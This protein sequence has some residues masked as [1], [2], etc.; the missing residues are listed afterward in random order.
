M[1]SS[2]DGA[3]PWPS[4]AA[5]LVAVASGLVVRGFTCDD[6][7]I[8]Y[9]FAEQAAAGHPLG[10]VTA[11][12]PLVSGFSNPTWTLALA[13]LARLGLPVAGSAKALGIVCF[14]LTAVLATRL[15]GRLTEHRA[16]AWAGCLVG[17]S[18]TLALWSVSGLENSLVAL[19]VVATALL[20]VAEEQDERRG[21]RSLGSSAAVAVLVVSR[22]DAFTYLAAAAFARALVVRRRPDAGWGTAVGD[23]ARWVAAPVVVLAG[24]WA[25]SL[26]RFGYVLANTYYAKVDQTVGDRLVSLTS[27][28]G[29]LAVTRD[30]LLITG[31][32]LIIP[33]VLLAWPRR[34]GP[35]ATVAVLA[36][37]TFVLPTSEVDWMADYRFYAVA[38]PLLIVLATVGADWA[39]G[40]YA[41][42][43]RPGSVLSGALRPARL[44]GALMI[45]WAIVNLAATVGLA[46]TDF[47]GQV[48]VASVRGSTAPLA[49]TGQD[50]GLQDPLV[51]TA[52]AGA[53][54]DDLDLRLLD[55]AG[56][57]DPQIS[58]LMAP[59]EL[60]HRLEYAFL[61]RRPDLIRAGTSDWSWN[62]RWHLTPATLADLGYLALPH[63]AEPAYVRRDL[64]VRSAVSR[65]VAAGERV[66]LD[67][68]S[69][70]EVAERGGQI[71]ARAWI[72]G[73][74]H[75]PGTTISFTLSRRGARATTVTVPL[76]A[77]LL[78][79]GQWA[80]DE[81][82]EHV[83]HLA[84]PAGTGPIE[85]T[86]AARHRGRVTVLGQQTIAPSGAVAAA[87]GLTAG[88]G[89]GAAERL[90]ALQELHDLALAAPREAEAIGAID[91]R[92]RHQGLT[93]LRHALEADPHTTG[94]ADAVE[95]D[96]RAISA[97]RGRAEPD[98]SWRSLAAR[99]HHRAGSAGTT[100]EERYRL[101]TVAA[102]A[103]PTSG[104][105][106]RDLLAARLARPARPVDATTA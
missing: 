55:L 73:G 12:D 97:L 70:P 31:A 87:D 101:L 44:C 2:S 22:P 6:A 8:T 52:D 1:R 40:R 77:D 46:R 28:S 92:I 25:F 11:G 60:D 84:P 85:L 106:Q 45:V 102:A 17:A 27:G 65:P 26:H 50:L 33:L 42:T 90:A 9:R 105:I 104:A 56:L 53:T 20:L 57:L 54:I 5:G 32:V 7:A 15:I 89:S 80:A 79:S 99:L 38:V 75:E 64:V 21:W 62:Q 24:W 63:I 100:A 67:E 49:A 3:G 93:D 59:D 95:T 81:A 58:H 41:T 16:A 74:P 19:L 48:T 82:L 66:T 47:P 88:L 96:R 13:A 30:F 91:K 14:A 103:D 23:V 34:R 68:L 76:G 69:A 94:G 51:M 29:P 86:V 43:G 37:A 98:A 4:V 83:A 61:E 39:A 36:A 10:T 78:A 18:S 72:D 35:V 71:V